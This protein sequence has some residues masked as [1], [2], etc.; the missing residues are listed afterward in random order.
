VLARLPLGLQLLLLLLLLP[1]LQLLLVPLGQRR[2]LGRR[3][4]AGGLLAA[5]AAGACVLQLLL[6]D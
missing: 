2:R 4:G 5:E 3:L 1:L 6:A